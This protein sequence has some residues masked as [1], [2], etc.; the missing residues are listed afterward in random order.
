VVHT[1]S[2]QAGFHHVLAEMAF[3]KIRTDYL[4]QHGIIP[5]SLCAN[6]YASCFQDF[7]KATPFGR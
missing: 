4:D 3:L 1:Y 5:V 2:Q 6:G 7:V